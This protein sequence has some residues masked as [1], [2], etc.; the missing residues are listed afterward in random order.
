M[1][2]SGHFFLVLAL[3]CQM[4][5]IY[6]ALRMNWVYGKQWAW[7]LIA[8]AVGAMFIRTVTHLI[9]KPG[10]EVRTEFF[11]LLTSLLVLGAI[12]M[13]DPMFRGI[14]KQT[15]VLRNEKRQLAANVKLRQMDI[16]KAELEKQRIEETLK[17][18]RER[19]TAII[20]TQNDIATAELDLNAVMALIV[21]RTQQITNASGAVIELVE[22]E[23]TVYRTA[24]GRAATHIGFR[25][26]MSTSFSGLSVRSGKIMRCDDAE[27]DQR[28]DIEECRRVGARSMIVLPLYY[29]RKVVG[30]LKVLSAE[31]YAFGD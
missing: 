16:E 13:V 17:Q 14:K 31:P 5:A 26:P 24:S 15:E 11:D 29:D 22:G 27:A 10:M 23:D 4:A 2:E 8:A 19:F 7:S 18:E 12:M 3:L 30:V 25:R 1:F 6:C 21:E 9:H 28:V 20:A